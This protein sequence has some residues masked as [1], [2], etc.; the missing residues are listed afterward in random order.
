MSKQ[1]DL[2]KRIEAVLEE[3]IIQ[4]VQK[5]FPEADWH[6]EW[7][8]VIGEDH[9]ENPIWSLTFCVETQASRKKEEEL[10]D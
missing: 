6:V 9:W 7:R 1:L 2:E 3:S 8:S 5:H 10:D 4:L